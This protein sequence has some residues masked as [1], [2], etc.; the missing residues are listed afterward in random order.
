MF[1]RRGQTSAKAHSSSQAR[2]VGEKHP[3]QAPIGKVNGRERWDPDPKTGW[4]DNK[5][6]QLKVLIPRN[7]AG[8]RTRVRQGAVEINQRPARGRETSR[9]GVSEVND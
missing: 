9:P 5:R 7:G 2:G 3:N 4:H 8:F 1:E 6:L